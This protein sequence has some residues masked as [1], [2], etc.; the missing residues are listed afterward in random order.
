MLMEARIFGNP[1][2][3]LRVLVRGVVVADEVQVNFR[4]S[5]PV[6]QPQEREPFL[7]AVPLAAPRSPLAASDVHGREQGCRTVADEVVRVPFGIGQPKGR[8]SC[9]RS[10]A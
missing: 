10:R 9:V 6:E 3:Y 2:P 1:G 5:L 4:G 7:V 8:I